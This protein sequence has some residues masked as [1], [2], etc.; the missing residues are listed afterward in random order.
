MNRSN[1]R[2]FQPRARH[3]P[4]LELLEG[5]DVPSA[6]VVNS[7]G[8]DGVGVAADH[9]DL[10]FCL[11]QSNARPGE[12]LIVFSV[13]GTINLTKA[14]PD[15]ADDLIIAGPGADQLMVR[16]DTG[17][18]YRIFTIDARVAAQVYSL[19]VSNGHLSADG[20]QGAGLSNAGNLTLADV[21]VTGNSVIAPNSGY[22]GGIYNAPS[23]VL[24]AFQSV[25]A[26]N[27]VSYPTG[28]STF[29]AA[30][31][32][33]ANYGT[34]A[35]VDSTVSLNTAETQVYQ[36][37]TRALAYG[38][39]VA[40]YGSLSLSTSTLA[41]NAVKS[42]GN[43]ASSEGG[44]L[45]SAGSF[46]AD[47]ALV[48][49]NSAFVNGVGDSYA[50]G[51][52]IRNAEGTAAVSS[53]SVSNNTASGAH[54]TYTTPIAEGAGISN[55]GSMTV[56]GSVVDGN[57]AP[58]GG[59]DS[60]I[61]HGAGVVNFGTLTMVSSD[62][63]GNTAISVADPALKYV[64]GGG[65]FNAG[66]LTFD[67][68][69]ASGNILGSKTNESHGG[70]IYSTGDLTVVNSTVALNHA[71]AFKKGSGGGIE[72]AGTALAVWNSTI[73]GNVTSGQTQLGGGVE[74]GAGSFRDTVVAGNQA[75]AGPDLYGTLKASSHDLFQK[76]AGGSGY[77]PTD[78]LD[79]DPILGPLQNNGGPTL[80]M[81]L[82]PGSPAIDSGDNTNAPDWDQRGPGYPRIVNGTID[83][84]AF[85]VQNTAGPAGGRSLLATA[86]VAAPATL[87]VPQSAPVEARHR[88]APM[89]T[90]VGVP[91]K[92]GMAAALSVHA[93]RRAA[94][95][96]P[97]AEALGL[98]A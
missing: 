95:Q 15:I 34:L 96:D 63:S 52:G 13:T 93:V 62:V 92:T 16:R 86:P 7:L 98:G 57:S 24:S 67:S 75:S 33:V 39:G 10:R 12:D 51:G 94:V 85:E 74:T 60:C 78:L 81:A 49:G 3:V 28:V 61:T 84:G 50:V 27:R 83:R 88:P 29:R 66:T 41:D 48:R 8:D 89:A 80:T 35:L 2:P 72:D 30:G 53:S 87:G 31:G 1:R 25:I 91:G 82:L 22:G 54:A 65:I 9:G 76:S 55:S 58:C 23:A 36:G 47:G 11:A 32:G 37:D 59:E 79:V 21:A 71:D 19:T 68:S 4:R 77:D 5:R 14:L 42:S 26:A 43:H 17:G 44:G 90:P 97:G 56:T 20:S 73:A 18:S 46:S 6:C 38:G 69:T 40:N 70:G 64:Y 45:F